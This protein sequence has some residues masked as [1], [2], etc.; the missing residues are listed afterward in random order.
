MYSITILFTVFASCVL[1]V[2]AGSLA[3]NTPTDLSSCAPVT[4]S[5]QASP[6]VGPPNSVVSPPFELDVLD[7]DEPCED[8]LFEL[9]H[10]NAT[11][12]KWAA[13]PLK[14]G[15]KVIFALTD[16]T[17]LE[18]W[19]SPVTVKAGASTTCLP[20]AVTSSP[21][22]S[23]GVSGSSSGSSGSSNVGGNVPVVNPEGAVAAASHLSAPTAMVVLGLVSLV[24]LVL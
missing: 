22:S 1:S 18:V 3:I 14:A 4:I 13:P 16:K 7:A 24:G 21:P 11:S 6:G 19:S 23:G 9:G 17:G 10:I 2:L 15:Q 20:N 5:W 8:A 12:Y